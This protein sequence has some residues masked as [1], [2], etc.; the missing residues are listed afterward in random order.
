[1]ILS[2]FLACS[3]WR[4]AA[5]VGDQLNSTAESSRLNVS[6]HSDN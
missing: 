3:L 2:V 4:E 6:Y 5:L 1:M